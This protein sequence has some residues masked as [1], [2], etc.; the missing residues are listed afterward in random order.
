MTPYSIQF[1]KVAFEFKSLF[2]NFDIDILNQFSKQITK[3]YFV[4]FNINTL[5]RQMFYKMFYYKKF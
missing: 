3:Q 1:N 5:S 2:N 4:N